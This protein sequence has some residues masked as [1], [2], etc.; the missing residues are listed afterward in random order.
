MEFSGALSVNIWTILSC[1]DLKGKNY[2]AIKLSRGVTTPRDLW[3][4]ES[5][6]EV[7]N[8]RLRGLMLGG[9]DVRQQKLEGHAAATPSF[10]GKCCNLSQFMSQII[11]I[12]SLKQ[13]PEH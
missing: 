3:D 4:S 10:I 11:D 13:G 2:L 5:T 8:E 9:W 1:H 7:S 12:T 6:S